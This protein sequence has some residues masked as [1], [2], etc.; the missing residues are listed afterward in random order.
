MKVK[1]TLIRQK[2]ELIT[3]RSVLQ[4]TLNEDLPA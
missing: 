2:I 1:E 3:I 4:E